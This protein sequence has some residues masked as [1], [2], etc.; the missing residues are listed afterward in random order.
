MFLRVLLIILGAVLLLLVVGPFLVPVPAQPGETAESLADSDSRFI[1]LNGLQ[2]HYKQAGQGE[3]VFILLHG[4]GASLFSWREVM[5]PLAAF[6]T[7]L[8]YDRTAF[9]L[10]ERPLPGSWNGAN[11]Y[12]PEASVEQLGALLDALGVRQ[13]VLVG[14]SAGGTVAL[15]FT[16]QHPERVQALI[17][18]DAA[19]YEGGG[20]PAYLKWLFRTP[21]VDHLGPLVARQLQVRGDDL[22]RTAWHDPAQ[23]G[24]DVLEGYR[25]PLR[26]QDWDRALWEFTKASH[27]LGLPARLAEIKPPVLVITGDDDRIVPTAL[28]LRLAREIPGAQLAVIPNSGHV[29]H[30]EQ[31]AAFLQAV[32]VFL[33]L[34]QP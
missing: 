2:V 12:A 10:T 4:F 20:G 13:A 30:E 18:V 14:N 19:I 11:P 25:K 26:V 17:L 28:S 22:I 24:A 21:Q 34:N 1:T 31:P 32:Q 7:V 15:N 16:L 29:P 6:G 9:G 3:P 8:A 5:Q 23:M 33:R 27:D